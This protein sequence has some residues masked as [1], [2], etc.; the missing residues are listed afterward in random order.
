[1]Q[2][3]PDVFSKIPD[4]L[5]HGTEGK[6]SAYIDAVAGK[7]G[8]SSY[9]SPAEMVSMPQTAKELLAAYAKF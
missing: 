9:C 5:Y 8:P 4:V 3:Y 1:M 7:F 2:Q 6:F